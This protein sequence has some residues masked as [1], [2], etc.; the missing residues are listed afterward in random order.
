NFCSHMAYGLRTHNRDHPE[1]QMT[2]IDLVQLVQQPP[3]NLDALLAHAVNCFQALN[4]CARTLRLSSIDYTYTVDEMDL[5]S[6]PPPT[7]AGLPNTI[8]GPPPELANL[9]AQRVLFP[10]RL[11]VG[12][13]PPR[14]AGL[15]GARPKED[16]GYSG[17]I[18]Q[19]YHIV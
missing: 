13:R 12:L 11:L 15:Y 8:A 18:Y 17:A 4:V 1:D 14:V 19:T 7:G 10:N 16:Q 9:K 3:D 6:R 2:V 5:L